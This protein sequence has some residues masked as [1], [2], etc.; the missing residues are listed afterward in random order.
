MHLQWPHAM[1]TQRS[2]IPIHQRQHACDMCAHLYVC[3]AHTISLVCAI[4][5]LNFTFYHRARHYQVHTPWKAIRL[6][7]T[8]I[9]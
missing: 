1:M 6:H 7:A 4:L 3:K 8:T 9:P 5:T 2:L